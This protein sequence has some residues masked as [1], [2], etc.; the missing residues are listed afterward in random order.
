MTTS[1]AKVARRT[2][3]PMTKKKSFRDKVYEDI[4]Q[5]Q[6]EALSALPAEWPGDGTLPG[7]RIPEDEKMLRVCLEAIGPSLED[8]ETNFLPPRSDASRCEHAF[9]LL[10]TIIRATHFIGS[11]ARLS[12]SQ[13]SYFESRRAVEGGRR[14][15][16]ARARLAEERWQTRAL[17]RAQEQRLKD[18]FIT[19]D[20]LAYDLETWL[21][22]PSPG[23]GTLL[24]FLTSEE[25][26]NRLPRRSKK[27]G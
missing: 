20:A 3:P 26:A 13:K 4:F 14:S 8:L 5:L 7:K 1:R 24:R 10:F 16:Q 22:E 11:R 17:K 12:L 19:Q 25:K 23:H 9:S 15:G 21:G 6:N 18:P 2:T 27:G